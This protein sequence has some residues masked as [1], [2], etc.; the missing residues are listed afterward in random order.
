MRASL[1]AALLATAFAGAQ[2]AA[3]GA[4]ADSAFT[5]GDGIQVPITAN[6]SPGQERLAKA[7][8]ESAFLTAAG[9]VRISRLLVAGVVTNSGETLG[10]VRDVMLHGSG[11]PQVILES[12]GR[13]IEVPWSKFAF[14]VPG[15][16]LHGKL[17]L[18]GETRHALDE[19]PEFEP[20]TAS[21]S[22]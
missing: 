15:K 12:S 4:T 14:D 18:P 13:L 20:A 2:S 21:G 3:H 5:D 19:L 17:V 10:T 22:G 7:S 8:Q 1:A 16:D 9:A 6:Q 11:Q